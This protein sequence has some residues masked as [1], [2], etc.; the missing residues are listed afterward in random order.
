[1]SP[2]H[3]TYIIA[4][5]TGEIGS[6]VAEHAASPDRRLVLMGRDRDRLRSI[7]GVLRTRCLTSISALPTALSVHDITAAVESAFTIAGEC[8]G[9][10][11]CIGS[12]QSTA[13]E[14]VTANEWATVVHDNLTLAFHFV[15]EFIKA[16]RMR[17][18]TGRSTVVIVGST[19]GVR[20]FPNSAA[21]CAAKHG[22]IGLVKS[23]GSEYS[24]QQIAICIV[25]P[26]L[27]RSD[28][29]LQH[30]Q[31]QSYATGETVD[32]IMR[33]LCRSKP[34]AEWPTAGDVGRL[35]ASLLCGSA[36]FASGDVILVE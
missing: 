11:F 27:L 36:S 13:F 28:S 10:A 3:R 8:H 6:A 35:V 18:A 22:L 23:I 7:E 1:M 26:G 2:P 31:E 34:F 12:N 5:A 30:V 25:C 16:S 14:A 21:Y 9:L 20:G 17:H 33:R 32:G 24:R 19:A 4:G 29:L 15:Q